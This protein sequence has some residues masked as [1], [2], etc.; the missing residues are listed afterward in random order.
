MVLAKWAGFTKIGEK[1]VMHRERKFGVTKFGF[2]RFVNGFLDLLSISFVSK[3]G[4]KPM[5][6]F[7][8]IGFVSFGL[9]LLINFYLLVLKIMGQDIWGKPILF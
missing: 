8:T 2:E 9:G 5:H 6:L 7:G 4:K 1:E 3:F